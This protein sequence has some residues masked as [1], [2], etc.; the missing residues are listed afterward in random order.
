ME[1][2]GT[3]AYPPP[4]CACSKIDL[5]RNATAL[6]G[7]PATAV[8]LGATRAFSPRAPWARL[9]GL[10]PKVPFLG[11]LHLGTSLLRIL[12][13]LAYSFRRRPHTPGSLQLP[14]Y[15]PRLGFLTLFAVSSSTGLASLFHPANAFQLRPSGV[16]PPREPTRLFVPPLPSCRFS[17]VALP[18]PR[19]WDQRRTDPNA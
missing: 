5:D 18:S 11:V 10:L 13:C 9:Q 19:R 17:A 7:I 6:P 16:S 1:V 3:L 12:C 15:G 8:T 14:G 2:A 4:A